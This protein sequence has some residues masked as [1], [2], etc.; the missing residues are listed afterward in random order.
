[1]FG[2]GYKFITSWYP[3]LSGGFRT[4]NYCIH[5]NEGEIVRDEKVI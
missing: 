5:D 4:S 1:M 3:Y 2:G